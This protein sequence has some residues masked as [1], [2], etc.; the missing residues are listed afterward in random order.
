[1]HDS[2]GGS[3]EELPI[4]EGVG[5]FVSMVLYSVGCRDS[6][7]FNLCAPEGSNAIHDSSVLNEQIV[8]SA[9][10]ILDFVERSLELG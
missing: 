9:Q 1:M 5:L 7:L 4:K 6:S 10:T 2:C 8:I 3:E